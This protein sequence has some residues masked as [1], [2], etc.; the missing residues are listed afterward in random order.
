MSWRFG[1]EWDV[2]Y[3]GILYAKD[4]YANK[5]EIFPLSKI[6]YRVVLKHL[7]LLNSFIKSYLNQKVLFIFFWNIV[8]GVEI[9]GYQDRFFIKLYFYEF[10]CS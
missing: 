4:F 9:K 3:Y 5:S 8:Q 6:F 2:E 7:K 10:V 1:C